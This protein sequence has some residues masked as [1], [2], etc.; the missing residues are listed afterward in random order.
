MLV[1][2]AKKDDVMSAELISDPEMRQR[3][4]DLDN[5]RDPA[6]EPVIKQ[7]GVPGTEITDLHEMLANVSN[8]YGHLFRMR[9]TNLLAQQMMLDSFPQADALPPELVRQ[10]GLPASLAETRQAIDQIKKR[11]AADDEGMIAE[12]MQQF[13]PEL[14]T[15][16]ITE[17]FNDSFEKGKLSPL[18]RF[19][20]LKILYK[21]GDHRVLTNYRPLA[22][23]SII[24]KIKATIIQMRWKKVLPAAIAECQ[25]GFIYRR[26]Q[27]ENVIPVLE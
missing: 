4:E 23:T 3:L 14:W 11:K 16:L 25:H 22:I 19:G 12:V 10:M 15:I 13:S 1:Y 6:I 24:Y 7:I 5:W 20:I 2:D 18:E 27:F 9:K 17:S 26:R 8:M 21:K